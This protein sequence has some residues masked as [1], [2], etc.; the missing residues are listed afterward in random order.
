MSVT[1]H[2][3]PVN[4]G[5]QTTITIDKTGSDTGTLSTCPPRARTPWLPF[6]HQLALLLTGCLKDLRDPWCR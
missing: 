3:V 4:G 2:A 5:E 6:L 1:I